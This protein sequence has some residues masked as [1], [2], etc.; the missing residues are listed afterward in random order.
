MI[1]IPYVALRA[2]EA[3]AV[4]VGYCPMVK[5]PALFHGEAIDPMDGAALFGQLN[6]QRQRLCVLARKCQVCGREIGR[7]GWTL[8]VETPDP[9]ACLDCFPIAWEH[10]PGLHREKAD[11][12]V[13]ETYRPTVEFLFA[14]QVASQWKLDIP[15]NV[16]HIAG[17]ALLTPCHF[18]R[19]VYSQGKE[20][21]A[22]SIGV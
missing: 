12:L 19:L 5:H 15:A 13:V 2:A 4:R 11:F 10:C 21:A 6:F 17:K 3:A 9:L 16:Q 20:L 7:Q 22:R 1:P 18:T 14:D 8:D